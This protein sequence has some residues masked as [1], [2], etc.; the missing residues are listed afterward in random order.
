MGMAIATPMLGGAGRSVPQAPPPVPTVVWWIAESGQSQGPFTPEQ[1]A[2]SGRLHSDTLVWTAGMPDW[3]PAAG[4]AALAAW[5]RP[6]P[7]R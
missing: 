3:Q 5:L 7:P 4:V 6:P 2:S 1:L